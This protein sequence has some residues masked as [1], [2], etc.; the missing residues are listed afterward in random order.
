MPKFDTI[1]PET[2]VSNFG[3]YFAALQ[4]VLD[5]V[6]WHMSRNEWTY[7]GGLEAGI[8]RY[9]SREYE[10]IEAF[11][12]PYVNEILETVRYLREDHGDGRLFEMFEDSVLAL[13]VKNYM[14]Y[15]Y[16]VGNPPYVRIK[17]LPNQDQK[18]Y[19][20]VYESVFGRFDLYVLFIERGLNW[21]SEDGILGFITSNKFTRSMY[22]REIRRII[23]D[24]YTLAEYVDFG[25]TGIFEDAANYPCMILVSRV[26]VGRM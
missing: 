23:S 10:G 14:D 19:E 12:E 25:D 5:V 9:T 13:V 18:Y 17:K 16:V 20:K 21:L 8:D 3:E 24:D 15:E 22:G 11:F 26:K 4:G 1:Q 6:K 2:G 7:G